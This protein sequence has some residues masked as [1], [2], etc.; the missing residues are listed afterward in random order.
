MGEY[1][2]VQEWNSVQLVQVNLYILLYFD[3]RKIR[4]TAIVTIKDEYKLVCGLSNGVISNDL[5]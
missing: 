3:R 1:I 4:D 5:E 2:P